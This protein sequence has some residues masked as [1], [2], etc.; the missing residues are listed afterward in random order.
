MYD[1]LV[2]RGEMIAFGLGA[3]L[4][5]IFLLTVIPNLDSFNALPKESRN[6]SDIFN[7]GLWLALILSGITVFTAVAA[8]IYQFI[9]N[10]RGSIKVLMG[11][12]AL[13]VIFG[14]FYATSTVETSGSIV[15]AAAEFN[16]DDNT[17][18]II[19][20]GIKTAILMSVGSVI[21]F[22]AAELYNAFK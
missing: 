11:L 20:A 22:I 15:D 18:K 2:K 5:L 4:V 6:T 12:A 14:I 16:V 3:L 8:G 17:S 10:P 21:T 7:T 9:S 13:A 19:S 1:F